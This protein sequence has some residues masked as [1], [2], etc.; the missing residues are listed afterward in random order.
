MTVLR[1]L[2][3]R[4]KKEAYETKVIRVPVPLIPLIDWLAD[5]FYQGYNSGDSPIE[6]GIYDAVGQLDLV[7][8]EKSKLMVIA[9]KLVSQKKSA[10]VTVGNL[11]QVLTK[12]SSLGN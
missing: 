5:R 2:G 11:L 12:D 3:G 6:S 7:I 9:E 1:P 4:G 8:V 10:R